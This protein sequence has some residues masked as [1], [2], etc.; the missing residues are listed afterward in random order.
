MLLDKF[1]AK[2]YPICG[3]VRRNVTERN[4]AFAWKI[5]V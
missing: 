4:M 3:K 2:F 1:R 5:V